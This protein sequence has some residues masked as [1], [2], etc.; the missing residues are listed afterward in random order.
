M[1][2]RAQLLLA[3][4]IVMG[5]RDGAAA[6][7]FVGLRSGY[8]A[9][10]QGD[11]IRD[12][13]Q[14]L[15]K[16]SE[17]NAG[18]IGLHVAHYFTQNLAVELS[19]DVFVPEVEFDLNADPD[20]NE[21]LPATA[22]LGLYPIGLSAR[23]RFWPERLTPVAFGGV[24]LV[25]YRF[26]VGSS[27]FPGVGLSQDGARLGAQAGV[28]AELPFGLRWLGTAELL[29]RRVDFK[30]EFLGSDGTLLEY[31]PNFSGIQFLVGLG[32]RF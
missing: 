4:A 15:V 10:V 20:P 28:G 1:R 16:G 5:A 12:L 31:Q 7:S 27:F 9:L 25:P 19:F 30:A 14:G 8:Y 18:S 32:Y 24:S 6:E 29:Y 13:F 17:F 23:Y 21:V 3:A 26:E 2:A 22:S 11:E